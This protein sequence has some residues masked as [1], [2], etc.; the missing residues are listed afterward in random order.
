MKAKQA[1]QIKSFTVDG[2][3]YASLMAH[4]KEAKS[5]LS[6]SSL[7]DDYL[8]YLHNELKAVL[9]FYSSHKI[10]INRAW[11]IN[12]VLDE[13]RLHPPKW[14]IVSL[15]SSMAGLMEQDVEDEA[16]YLLEEYKRE[17]EDMVQGVKDKKRKRQR[18]MKAPG[19]R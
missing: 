5:G 12:K 4:L 19:K 15:S 2:D 9:G 7:I 11:V 17:Q 1:K 10:E 14:D 13:A 18:L 8:G 3:V 16:L 6:V